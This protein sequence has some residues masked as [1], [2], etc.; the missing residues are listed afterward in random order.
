MRTVIGILTAGTCIVTICIALMLSFILTGCDET[1][2]Q[3]LLAAA[4]PLVDTICQTASTVGTA[5][6][7][8]YIQQQV[9]EGNLTSEQA[10]AINSAI[11]SVAASIGTYNKDIRSPWLSSST[12]N[13]VV[14]AALSKLK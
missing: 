2:A 9:T 13:K 3:A 11:S 6:A 4:E 10:Q 8:Q 5:A 7:N 12:R 14:D 1:Q